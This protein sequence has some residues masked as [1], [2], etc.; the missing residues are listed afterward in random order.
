M[1]TLA[2]LLVK[3]YHPCFGQVLLSFTD[4]L[5]CI[6]IPAGLYIGKVN[7]KERSI[8]WDYFNDAVMQIQF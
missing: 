8:F 5:P 1:R 6:Q 4:S 7:Y 2:L 3:Y